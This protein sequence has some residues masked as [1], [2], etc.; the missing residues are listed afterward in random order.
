MAR[1]YGLTKKLEK[2]NIGEKSANEIIGNGNLVDITVRMETLLDP[3]TTYQILDS[4]A[5]GTSKKELTGIKAIDAGTIAEKIEKIA[6]L[7]DFHADWT[8][9][10]NPDHTLT[11]GWE[12]KKFETYSCVCS[13]AVDKNTKVCDLAREGRTMPLVYCLCCAGH[14]RQH[15]EKLLDIRLKTKEVVSSPINSKGQQPC[16]FI[17]EMI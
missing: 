4:C 2:H 9:A 5:C 8:V 16:K 1:V 6:L 11:A 10:L 7:G 12:I 15:L 3:E 17:L 14:C 13:A